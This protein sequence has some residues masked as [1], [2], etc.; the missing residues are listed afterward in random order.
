MLGF[1]VISTVSAFLLTVGRGIFP[2]K[3]V[4]TDLFPAGSHLYQ[5][6]IC[7][8]I[9]GRDCFIICQQGTVRLA[10]RPKDFLGRVH[11]TTRARALEFAR[12]MSDYRVCGGFEVTRKDDILGRSAGDKNLTAAIK[13]RLN[14]DN[15]IVDALTFRALHAQPQ[16][17]RVLGGYKVHR[18]M[19]YHQGPDLFD[20]KAC[21]QRVEEFIGTNGEY[22]VKPLSVISNKA[23]KRIFYSQSIEW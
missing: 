20:R 12:L 8:T 21:V 13:M 15:G 9:P 18:L 17:V 7:E 3:E 19:V 1:Q 22:R 23:A 5:A 11:V 2:Q 6:R 4:C 10:F 16:V 14:G